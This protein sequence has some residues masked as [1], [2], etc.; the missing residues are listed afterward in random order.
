[1]KRIIKFAVKIFL[2]AIVALGISAGTP[3]SQA[4][5]GSYTTTADAPLRSGPGS[6]YD[7]I[8]TL[9]KGIQ[10]NVV[11]KEGYWLKVESKHG[12]KPGYIDEQFAAR[13]VAGKNTQSKA[14][15]STVAGPYRTLGEVDLRQGPG[16]KFPTVTRLPAD[17]KVNVVHAEGDWLRVESKKGGKPGYVDKRDVERWQDR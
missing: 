8:T 3:F 16:T 4:T 13:D 11:G 15:A 6:N 17:I 5:K 2:L 7:T 9:P 12:G 1:M 14:S 10:V